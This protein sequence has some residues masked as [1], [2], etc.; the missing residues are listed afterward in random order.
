MIKKEKEEKKRGFKISYY[1]PQYTYKK[2]K[3]RKNYI[4]FYTV[5]II[6]IPQLLLRKNFRTELWIR[7]Y[8]DPN[9][10]YLKKIK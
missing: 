4:F 8:H 10:G 5:F 3:N 9:R 1:L 2:K 7:F 6:E